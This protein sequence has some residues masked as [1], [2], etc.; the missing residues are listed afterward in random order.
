MSAIPIGI[1]YTI[2]A[3]PII[4]DQTDF[5]EVGPLL[6]GVEYRHIDDDEIEQN[7]QNTGDSAEMRAEVAAS[8]GLNAEPDEGLSLHVF[9]PKNKFEHLRFD[10]FKHDPHYHY[11]YP[12]HHIMVPFDANANGS[13][14]NWISHILSSGQLPDMLRYANADHLAS[15]LDQSV[16]NDLLER[17]RN[18]RARQGLDTS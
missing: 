18:V 3:I 16:A 15:A 8:R 1:H 12:D 13:M 4:E 2:P 5:L 11:M 7:L 6:V 9:D 10:M 14:W 17:V